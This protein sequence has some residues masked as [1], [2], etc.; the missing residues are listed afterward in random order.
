MLQAET[1]K[2]TALPAFL[3]VYGVLTLIIFASLFMGFA[4]D[5]HLLAEGGPLNWTI[6]DDI[7]GHVAPMLFII[8]LVW[9]VFFFLAARRPPAYASFLSFTMWANFLH[10]LL[11]A[12]QASTMMHRYWGKWL[13]DIPFVWI[14]A[15][16][17]YV[18]RPD[19]NSELNA[20][21][22]GPEAIPR[23]PRTPRASSA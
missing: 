19:P 7:G 15:L 10:G 16:G 6:W 21:A 20:S 11:M 22:A 12:I 8:Y 1:T 14:L 18:W 13:T 9:G 17:I 23:V 5:T 2:V 3:R 4:F